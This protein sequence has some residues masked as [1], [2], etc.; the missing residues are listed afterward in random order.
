[1]GLEVKGGWCLDD[2]EKVE[3]WHELGADWS[4]GLREASA[5]RWAAD[6]RSSWTLFWPEECPGH[7]HRCPA[8]KEQPS[9]P[10]RVHHCPPSLSLL[11]GEGAEGSATRWAGR[12]PAPCLLP[13]D[14]HTEQM[15][16]PE[17]VTGTSGTACSS[18][19]LPF[20]CRPRAGRPQP[21]GMAQDT[22]WPL[23][24]ALA[25]LA[26]MSCGQQEHVCLTSPQPSPEPG[27]EWKHYHN[28]ITF[29]KRSLS[30]PSPWSQC[31]PRMEPGV[32]GSGAPPG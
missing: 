28:L 32:S 17:G 24:G 2:V 23:V 15:P 21:A 3:G 5:G 25:R 31:Q 9:C 18:C 12:R 7:K 30:N 26:C 4:R 8:Q 22:L 29:H 11:S 27:S 16:H 6:L 20:V 13:S 19:Q 1:M 10:G 14:T